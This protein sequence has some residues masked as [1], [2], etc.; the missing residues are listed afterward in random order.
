MDTARDVLGEMPIDGFDQAKKVYQQIY[1]EIEVFISSNGDENN[2]INNKMTVYCLAKDIA[3][4][5]FGLEFLYDR[6]IETLQTEPPTRLIEQVY[7]L[8]ILVNKLGKLKV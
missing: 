3:E 5:R 7:D 6:T 8:E 4:T 2:N 1:K